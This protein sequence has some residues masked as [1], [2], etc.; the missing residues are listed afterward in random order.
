MDKTVLV[1]E[2][3]AAALS[4]D[5]QKAIR[6]NR[7]IIK[8]GDKD[9]GAL[10]RLAQAYKSVGE[11]KKSITCYGKVLKIDKY[12]AIAQR[13]LEALKGN[14]GKPSPRPPS[15]VVNNSAILLEEPG[16]TKLVNLVNL[17]PVA[18]ILSLVPIQKL[19]LT[20]KR[21][22]VFVSD[23]NDNYIGALPDDVSYRLM[24]FMNSGYKYA[25][26]VKSVDR[27]SLSVILREYQRSKRLKNQPSFPI[28]DTMH[29]FI[30]LN[31]PGISQQADI[32]G[33]SDSFMPKELQEEEPP[34]EEESEEE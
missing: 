20:I 13:N 30:P 21:K 25:C 3:V 10:N 12:N 28:G 7:Q 22:A 19:Q 26:F 8:V 6:L 2:A 27:N 15:S 29:D 24:K 16:K 18:K 34:S 31:A 32:K 4:G 9:C 1:E 33:K 23:E 5:W 11:T 14:R 17:A